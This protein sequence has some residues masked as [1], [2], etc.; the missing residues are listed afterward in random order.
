MSSLLTMLFLRKL[1]LSHSKKKESREHKLC[2][3]KQAFQQVTSIKTCVM[4][5]ELRMYKAKTHCEIHT[6]VAYIDVIAIN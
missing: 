2:L 3:P 4:T 5:K 1:T 6:N